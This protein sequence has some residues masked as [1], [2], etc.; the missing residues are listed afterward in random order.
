M[1]SAQTLSIPKRWPLV[2]R[3]QSRD[4]GTPITRDARLINC[5]AEL[6]P[7][8]QEYY[9][10]KRL[11][12]SP[13]PLWTESPVGGSNAGG[14][15]TYV[16][17]LSANHAPFVISSIGAQYYAATAGTGTIVNIGP[18]PSVG[19][20]TGFFSY[21]ETINSNPQTVVIQNLLGGVI[22]TPSTN[23]FVSITD[24][25]FTALALVP[26]W[27]YLDGWLFVMDVNGAIWGT[28]NQNNALVWSGT[29]KIL[30][31]TQADQGMFIATQLTY[32]IAFKQ[33]TTQPFY[34]AGNPVGSP[35]S[36]I[37]NAQIPYGCFS[38][39]TVQKIDEI[40][41]WVTANRVPS[42]QVVIMENLSTKIISTPAIDRVLHAA[43]FLYGSGGGSGQIFSWVTKYSGH[44]W[45]GVT[46]T[47]LNITLVYDLDQKLWYIWSDPSGNMWPVA[48][49]TYVPPLGP[50][51]GNIPGQ[52]IIQHTTNGGIYTMDPAVY[53]D[54]GVLFPMDIY[55]PN[56]TG[57]TQRSKSLNMLYFLADKVQGQLLARY[58]DDDYN[59]W[60]NFRSIDLFDD[61]PLLDQDGSFY[62]RAYHFRYLTNNKLRI[63]SGDLQ[64][65]IGTL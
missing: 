60:S 34:D 62:R 36:P 19:P 22:Y 24:V 53:S 29:N 14:L 49:M 61:R 18:A 2:N 3:F 21:F 12:I 50:G 32:V 58:S 26:G 54:L 20:F 64:L 65:D 15:Y 35:L 11:G 7:E 37:P 45:Y 42:A 40:L 56:F 57:G 27:A 4:I 23:A 63:K 39:F 10:Y 30:A 47:T 5:F 28:Q 51:Q 31:S 55:T 33:W 13:T 41:I 46:F 9:I 52:H 44:R 8:D 1:P 48:A 25:N 17:P 6:D 16:F 38:G 59:T 43:I